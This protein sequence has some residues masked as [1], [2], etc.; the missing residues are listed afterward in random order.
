MAEITASLVKELRVASGAGMMDC[1]KA[2]IETDGDMNEAQDWLRKKGLAS[3]AKKAGR[4]AAEGL[5]GVAVDGTRGA[6]VELNAETD[7]VARNDNFQGFVRQLA[8]LALDAGS[9]VETLTASQVAG[10]GQSVAESLTQ[11][12][13]KIGENMNLR[14]TAAVSVDQ[15]A[16]GAYVHNQA[17]PGLGKIGVLVALESAGDQTAL[18]TLGKQLAMHVAAA[19]PQAIDA[20]GVDA[21]AVERERNILAEQARASGKPEEIVQKMVDGRHPQVLRGRGACWSRPGSSTMRAR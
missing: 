13:S 3:A 16:V 7:F 9:S 20:A 18:A 1:K 5:I 2:L 8:E 14:R 15:G 19:S 17:A 21:S 10:T 6:I 12:I 11:L 4:T